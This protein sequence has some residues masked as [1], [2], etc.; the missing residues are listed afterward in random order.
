MAVPQLK[1]QNEV[2]PEKGFKLFITKE[3]DNT[4]SLRSTDKHFTSDDYLNYGKN[5]K[6]TDAYFKNAD[7]NEIRRKPG[8]GESAISNQTLLRL[9]S[10]VFEDDLARLS[11][12]DK[13]A[14]LST[15]TA[16]PATKPKGSVIL[17]TK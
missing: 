17:R 2:N 15:R 16:R 11:D 4:I 3:S 8:K 14:S 12:D 13:K 1:K 9:A 6:L 5:Y 7:S 10:Q